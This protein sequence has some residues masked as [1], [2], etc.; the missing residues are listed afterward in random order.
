MCLSVC[1]F[2]LSAVQVNESLPLQRIR[3]SASDNDQVLADED[4]VVAEEH[5]QTHAHDE[6][7]ESEES[8]FASSTYISIMNGVLQLGL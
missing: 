4:E 5:E 3:A 6:D 1:S 7:G 2:R 8:M